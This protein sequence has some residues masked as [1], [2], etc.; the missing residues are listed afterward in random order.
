M[1]KVPEL[2]SECFPI[3]RKDCDREEEDVID[4]GSAPGSRG[5]QYGQYNTLI[6]ELR[7]D[8]ASSFKRYLRITPTMFDD[9]LQRLTPHSQKKDTRFL[10][11]LPAG[12]KLAITLRYMASGDTYAS[13]AYDYGVAAGSV[14]HFVPEVYAALLKEYKD[15]VLTIPN[16]PDAWLKVATQRERWWNMPH[17]LGALDGK[18]VKIKKPPGSGSLYHNYKGF[19]SIVLLALVDANCKFIWCDLLGICFMS[20]CKIFNDSALKECM[21]QNNYKLREAK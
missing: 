16:T 2:A 12:I 4:V 18:H 5:L 21:A 14:C 8:D 17:T 13:L 10:Y 6:Q 15:D 3:V 1:Q 20:D 9:I 19:F 11:A 7:Y